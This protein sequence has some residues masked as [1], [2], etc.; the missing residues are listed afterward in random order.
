MSNPV[1]PADPAEYLTVLATILPAGT[2]V[3]TVVIQKGLDTET[4][5]F[6]ALI[7]NA[8]KVRRERK[9]IGAGGAVRQATFTIH[10]MYL[11]RWESSTRTLEQILADADTA[12][13]QMADNVERN[14]TLGYD[15]V[16][17]GDEIDVDVDGPVQDPGLGFPLVTGSIVISIKSP[18]Y[19]P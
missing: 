4:A 8:P 9:S 6:P 18:Y 13:H 10:G 1:N 16:Q 19:V 11:D 2:P 17:A 7:L 15:S 14:P 5:A 12:L 3:Q